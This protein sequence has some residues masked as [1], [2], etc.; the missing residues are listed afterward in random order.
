MSVEDTRVYMYVRDCQ[1]V[2]ALRRRLGRL[3]LCLD[4]NPD[5]VSSV[6][7]PTRV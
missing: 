1:S 7:A 2:W 6:P 5:P 4:F 3:Y